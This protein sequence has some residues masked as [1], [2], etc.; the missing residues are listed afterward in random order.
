MEI[1]VKSQS[2]TWVPV[3]GGRTGPV[4]KKKKKCGLEVGER[5]LV[6]RDTKEITLKL[7]PCE[8]SGTN[9]HVVSKIV[10]K[11]RPLSNT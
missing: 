2:E 1:L 3:E 5:R 11:W 6:D 10:G 4:K 8:N 7:N 9:R